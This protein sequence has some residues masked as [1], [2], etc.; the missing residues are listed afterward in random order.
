MK[1][2]TR[3]KKNKERE[4]ESTH[5]HTHTHNPF[6][7]VFPLS[8][9]AGLN[10]FMATPLHKQPVL[11][12]PKNTPA[13]GPV[14]ENSKLQHP[15]RSEGRCLYL[16]QQN[17]SM[18]RASLAAGLLFVRLFSA[19]CSLVDGRLCCFWSFS[20]F[21]QFRTMARLVSWPGPP[22]P[23]CPSR[24]PSSLVSVSCGSGCWQSLC[25]AVRKEGSLQRARL[26]YGV[27]STPALLS[28]SL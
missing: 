2:N 6:G 12:R 27:R 24:R 1:E 9:R 25:P 17:T 3:K 11:H 18:R 28:R 26:S 23:C 15:P 21:P 20:P 14:A 7:V 8:S 16:V 22:C 19:S 10:S 5:I 13:E 4:T